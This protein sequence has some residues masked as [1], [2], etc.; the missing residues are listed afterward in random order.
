LHVNENESFASI[1]AV[2]MGRKT[3]ELSL[4]CKDRIVSLYKK[5]LNYLKIGTHLNVSFAT[6]QCVIKKFL[7]KNSI[8]NKAI[9]PTQS[10]V[11]KRFPESCAAGV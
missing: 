6:V 4:V 10:V 11:Y 8:E 3:K 7:T 5:G 1:L 9:R 2:N